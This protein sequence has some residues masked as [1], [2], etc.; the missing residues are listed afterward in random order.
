[1]KKLLAGILVVFTV[2]I[3]GSHLTYTIVGASSY[4][5]LID[6]KYFSENGGE[7]VIIYFDVLKNYSVFSYLNP[8]KTYVVYID[9]KDSLYDGRTI[10]NNIGGNLI[11]SVKYAQN[12]KDVVR[13]VLYLKS[14]QQYKIEE[15]ADY[16]KIYVGN[17]NFDLGEN[18]D[19]TKTDSQQ[20]GN[21]STK[22]TENENNKD[23]STAQDE[24]QN[25]A[26]S[27]GEIERGI[28]G[29]PDGISVALADRSG[30]DEVTISRDSLE[31]YSISSLTQPDRV[32][33][34]IKN[35]DFPEKMGEVVVQG[36][37]VTGI[38]YAKPQEN[39]GRIV[40]DLASK[41]TY[42]VSESDGKI[43]LSIQ[44]PVFRTLSI[45]D[46]MKYCIEGDRV[47][48]ILK[49]AVLTEGGADLKTN[50]TAKYDSTGKIY[51]VTFPTKYAA[52]LQNGVVNLNDSMF[53]TVTIVKN[54][55]TSKTSIVFK[56]REK[57]AYVIMSRPQTNDTAITILRPSSKGDKLV[58]IDAGHGGEE[59][60]AVNGNL[61]EKDINLDIA[62]RLNELLKKKNI[63]TY[64][65]REKDSFVG[66]YERAFIAN[67]LNAALFIS[68]HNNAM[69]DKSYGG[70]MTLYHIKSGEGSGFNS[71]SFA[72]NLQNSLVKTL[73]T[74]D[75][76]TRARPD[77]VVLKATKMPASLAEI[78]FMTNQT[79]RQNLQ[80]EDFRQKAA[81]ALCDA[82]VKSLSEIK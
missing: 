64:M 4:S 74:S 10:R 65:I 29:L 82:I 56:A 9:F 40:L 69:E 55:L 50:Y 44:K 79:D 35:L 2:L 17:G 1:M 60:G 27:R 32:Y 23:N 61:K 71:L 45:S 77:L 25:T 28:I 3:A 19:A 21:E 8:D 54:I 73:G 41:A 70:T 63:N 59:P 38:R 6:V 42:Q 36:N 14:E 11:N 39:V 24:R 81:Q 15:G 62:L 53:E 57:F 34:D 78:A 48:F 49:G 12:Q 26:D 68:I 46:N 47:Y 51:T 66:L 30:I 75:R 5:R 16:L 76:N 37:L 33:I 7:G 43:V 67:S 58:V 72:K 22:E 31:N 52:N 13:V 80:K 20:N 18:K